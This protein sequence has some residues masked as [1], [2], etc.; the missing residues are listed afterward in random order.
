MDYCITSPPISLGGTQLRRF[1]YTAVLLLTSLFA[2]AATTVTVRSVSVSNSNT[3]T[4]DG[5]GFSP[6]KGAVPVVSI[7]GVAVTVKNFTDTRIVGTL[8][9]PVA[10]EDTL[11]VTNSQGYST[12]FEFAVKTPEKAHSSLAMAEERTKNP[13]TS[14][15]SYS[16]FEFAVERPEKAHSPLASAG[17]GTKKPPISTGS[18]S[19]FGSA[20]ETPEKAPSSLTNAEEGKKKPPISTESFS[21]RAP[22][23]WYEEPCLVKEVT[24]GVPVPRL[25]S[26]CYERRGEPERHPDAIEPRHGLDNRPE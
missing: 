19:D 21:D 17:E 7:N 1:A 10:G 14:R 5:S 12:T 20:V 18:S 24:P 6:T 9:V 25:P 3:Y 4:I 15:G 26:Y 11:K 2:I 8:S 16:G 13:P 22:L 23:H